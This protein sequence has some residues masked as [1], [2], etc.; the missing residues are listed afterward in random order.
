MS[1]KARVFFKFEFTLLRTDQVARRL[2][3]L[4]G[5]AIMSCSVP[6][7][8]KSSTNHYVHADAFYRACST[9]RDIISGWEVVEIK[10]IAESRSETYR[11]HSNPYVLLDEDCTCSSVRSSI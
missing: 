5:V 7:E 2:G 3:S 11:E 9:R 8:R 1:F 10:T 6:T 4:I